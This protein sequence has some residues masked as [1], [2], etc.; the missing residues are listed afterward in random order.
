MMKRILLAALTFFALLTV[1]RGGKT[2]QVAAPTDAS[3]RA[4]VEKSLPLLAAG[5]RGS[6]EKRAQCFTCHS[7]GLTILALSAAKVRGFKIDEEELRRQ[8]KFTVDFL[9]TNRKQYLVGKGQGGQIDT[10]GYALWA[11]DAAGWK[12]DA[13]T[14][15]VAEYL[16]RWQSELDYWRPTSRRP[17]TQQ[18]LFTSTHV[19]LYGLKV[20]GTPEQKERQALRFA[21]VRTWLLK[22]PA[23]DTEDRVF[24]LRALQTAD[25]PEAELRKAAQELAQQQ[26]PD[27]G[28]AQN[29]TMDTDVYATATALVVLNEAG[30]LATTDASYRKGLRYLLE[31]QLP[32]GSWH[33]VTRSVPIQTYFESGYPHGKD[34]FISVSAAAWATTAL[35]RALP[36]TNRPQERGRNPVGSESRCAACTR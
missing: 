34:Q 9:E 21:Q 26:K 2:D 24:R 8:V 1:A 25:A 14:G 6:V 4:A 29:N 32:D 18:S 28:W 11:L 30:G 19:A 15:A 23:V 5:A 13:T 7:Q 35:A 17:P 10:A 36:T 31:K 12:P 20:F 3:L 33:V 16:L 22:T 27:G